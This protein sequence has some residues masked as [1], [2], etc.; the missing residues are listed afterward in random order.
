MVGGSFAAHWLGALLSAPRGAAPVERESGVE[1]AGRVDHG[2]V[3]IVPLIAGLLIAVALVWLAVRARR[4]LTGRRSCGVSPVWF[5]VLP[6]LGFAAQE[7]AERALHAE[8]IPFNPA[9]EPAFLTGLV[10][11]LPFGMLAYVIGRALRGLGA[12]L[13]RIVSGSRPVVVASR[14][15]PGLRPV[16]VIRPRIPVL[17]LGH[18][19]R[20]PPSMTAVV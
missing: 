9:H 20:G 5:L 18:S 8:A 16:G 1:L 7:M 2:S 14:P 15:T 19:V 12:R 17:A 6:F 11:Q 13:A 10:L 3:T 4:A